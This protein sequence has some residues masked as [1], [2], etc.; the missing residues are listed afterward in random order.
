MTPPALTPWSK[1][2]IIDASHFDAETAYAADRPPSARR[3]QALHLPHARRRQDAGR[4]IADGIP[5]GSF[6]NAV[7]EDP[8]R[9]GLLYAGTEKGVYVS[10]DDGDHWQPLQ[11][12]LPVTSVRDIDVH[13]DDL[14]D[15]HARPRLLDPG[16]R[17]AAAAARRGGDARGR[18]R[19]SRP[20][21]ADRG[22]A[23]RGFTG[24]P[25]PEG[26]ADGPQ[27]ARRRGHRLRARDGAAT[28]PVTLAILD[29]AGRASCAATAATRRLPAHRPRRRSAPRRSG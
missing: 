16:Q 24:T 10:F 6:V 17:H 18:A 2:G 5:D 21:T 23:R 20:P 25:L 9:K 1:V 11:L 7:R 14:V 28:T 13:G 27:P 22:C 19:S 26:R 3:L 29:D 4:S 15:R 8:V 12:N